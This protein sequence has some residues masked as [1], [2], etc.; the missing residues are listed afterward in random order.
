MTQAV[1][2]LPHCCWMSL[3][4]KIWLKRCHCC[5][6]S[7]CVPDPD[8]SCSTVPMV[9]EGW[10]SLVVPKIQVE[11]YPHVF[12]YNKGGNRVPKQCAQFPMRVT[13]SI[14]LNE[15]LLSFFYKDRG[16]SLCRFAICI[17]FVM[18][19]ECQ[20]VDHTISSS[21][22][23]LWSQWMQ[24][25]ELWAILSGTPF[26][27]VLQCISLATLRTSTIIFN[28]K[29]CPQESGCMHDV[30]E[31]IIHPCVFDIMPFVILSF[32]MHAGVASFVIRFWVL[33]PFC[34]LKRLS[35]LTS[36]DC[37]P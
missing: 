8:S 5:Q 11:S 15:F 25:W 28:Q 9:L 30:R 22:V 18:G 32:I 4:L 23:Y 17:I 37:W 29:C 36:K 13:K 21:C 27:H 14:A 19:S 16:S 35:V 1:S 2:P 33:N 24:Y 26:L 6:I 12:L 7:I 20:N 3:W 34:V 10:I 31:C